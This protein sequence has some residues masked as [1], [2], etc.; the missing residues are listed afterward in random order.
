MERP[1]ITVLY[2]CRSCGLKDIGVAV[3]VRYENE[4]VVSWVNKCAAATGEDHARRSPLCAS[5]TGDLKIPT[6]G[7]LMVGGPLCH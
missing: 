6:D 3:P 4:D 2:A 5:E 1:T 7:R